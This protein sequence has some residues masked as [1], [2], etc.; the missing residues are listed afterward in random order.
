MSVATA[1]RRATGLPLSVPFTQPL[2]WAAGIHPA[3]I[4]SRQLCYAGPPSVEVC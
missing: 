4:G 1:L 2:S 3:R